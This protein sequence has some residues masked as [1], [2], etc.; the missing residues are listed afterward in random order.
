M[1]PIDLEERPFHVH[2]TGFGPFASYSSNPS[3]EAVK[4]L[5]DTVLAAPPTPLNL[6][7]PRVDPASPCPPSR[8]IRLT[9]SLLPVTYAA[10]SKFVPLLHRGGPDGS[11]R[12]DLVIHCGVG[13]SGAVKLEQRARK[14]G[15]EKQDV[16]G[17]LA[18]REEG[19]GVRR[20]CT[21]Q[22]LEGAEEELRTRIDGKRVQDWLK[23]S[24]VEHLDLSED[25]GLYLCEFTYYTSLAS[26]QL[27]GADQPVPVQFVHV[28]P[29]NN[30][31]S[32]EQ[33]T[34][35]LKLIIWAIV[36]EGGLPA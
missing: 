15:Y 10:A 36:N 5:N 25:A 8:P 18:T 1:P 12:P 9:S 29:L 20:G 21:A 2:L 13:L 32:L 16:D 4:P 6:P 14:W 28:P 26:S 35:I 7:A 27:Y 17:E 19:G 33:L 24:G 23:K 31:Y 3:W 22:E 30:P 11:R 34:T